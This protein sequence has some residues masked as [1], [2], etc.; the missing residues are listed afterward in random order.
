MI[1]SPITILGLKVLAFTP[2]DLRHQFVGHNERRWI[3]S[4]GD[5]FLFGPVAGLGICAEL[6]WVVLFGCDEVWRALWETRCTTI[7]VA[8]DQAEF[9]YEG[10]SRTWVRIGDR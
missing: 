1:D 3:D 7:A 5:E 2:I 9:E 4:K 6:D 8:E 10:V